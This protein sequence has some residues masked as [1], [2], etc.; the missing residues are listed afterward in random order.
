[1]GELLMVLGKN[2]EEEN[3]GFVFFLQREGPF[4]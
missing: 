2:S 1:M 3:F 4:R